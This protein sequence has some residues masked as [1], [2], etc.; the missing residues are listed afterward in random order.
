MALKT[1][2]GKLFY[3]TVIFNILVCLI[4]SQ[5]VKCERESISPNC[6]FP[7]QKKVNPNIGFKKY[8][9]FFGRCKLKVV[10]VNQTYY[11]GLK[12]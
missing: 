5:F 11:L 9:I 4:E 3:L 12:D 2:S 1:Q 7:F 8:R 10:I 6:I